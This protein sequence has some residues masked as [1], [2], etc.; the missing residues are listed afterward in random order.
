MLSSLFTDEVADRGVDHKPLPL[1]LLLTIGALLIHGYHPWA[2]DAE[3]YLPGVEKLLRPELFPFGAE[4]F[5]HHASLT[6]FPNFLAAL[7]RA[8]HLPLEWV[9]FLVHLASVFLLLLAGWD[10]SNKCFAS[11]KACWGAVTLLAALLTLPVAGTALYVMD[12]Y[13]NPRNLT[14]FALVFSIS[15]AVDRKYVQ[16]AV[17]LCLAA[18]IHPLM[19]V[20]ALFLCALI[21]A[22]ERFESRVPALALLL[23]FG[24]TFDPPSAAYHEVAI[25][26]TYHYLLK[27][28][29]FEWLGIV[30]PLV[31][32]WWFSRV[33]RSRRLPKLDLLCRALIPYELV[34]TGGA[35]I[36][37]VSARFESLARVQ[38]MRSLHL[39]YILL[40]LIGGGFLAE[41]VLKNHVWRWLVLFVPVCAG[42]W[43]AQRALFPASAHIEW[44]GARPQSRWVQAF[45]WIRENTPVDAIFAL[46]PF[47]MQKPG[48][49]A[50]GFRAI[51]Q[52]SMLADAVK[53]SGAVTMFPPMAE[54]W[55]RQVR[56]Q[57]DWKKF[58]ASDFQR[59]R[60]E[61][62]VTW[63]VLEQ[64]GMAGASCPYQNEAVLVCRNPAP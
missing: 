47:H 27:W 30:G 6:L 34:C 20:F 59:L 51:A 7:V 33:A 23:P 19:S 42:M 26:H 8:S 46:D 22:M 50:N 5:Q 3:I 24:I 36:L 10:L 54:E 58:Q 21:V 41:Y 25:S 15:K 31:I 56:A 48:E 4:F 9:L 1:L 63:L 18:T 52:R 40:V 29:W 43:I 14:A 60:A 13:V 16:G 45:V 57:T 2:E 37:S 64:P 28:Q 35:L 32:L 61:Y 44:P 62:G 53:D 38:P 55:Q 12:Q 17:F 11:R 39:L 49:D